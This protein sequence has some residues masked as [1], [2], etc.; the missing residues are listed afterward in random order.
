MIIGVPK[1]IKSNEH[2]VA[3]Q[4]SGTE[5]LVGEGH[6]VYIEKGAGVG[7]G[8]SDED[9]I[10]SGAKI[11]DTPE[12]IFDESEM[13]IKVKE[14]LEPEYP[15]MKQGQVMFTYFHFTSSEHLNR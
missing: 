12:E 1:E 9:Y 7:S 11:L 2:R 3:L 5:I 6:S 14:P 15:L 8:F 4:P 10:K 13:I